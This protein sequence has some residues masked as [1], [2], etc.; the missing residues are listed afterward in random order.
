L[1]FAREYFYQHIAAV[2]QHSGTPF[3][4][5]TFLAWTLIDEEFFVFK[6]DSS[7]VCGKKI[8]MLFQ[9]INF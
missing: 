8:G 6:T 9:K 5:V 7:Q 2:S 1:Y 4:V 3:A